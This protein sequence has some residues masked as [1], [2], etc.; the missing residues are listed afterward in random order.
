MGSN[1]IGHMKIAF[2]ILSEAFVQY[3]RESCQAYDWVKPHQDNQA[4]VRENE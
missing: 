3:P 1:M 2:I 4:I